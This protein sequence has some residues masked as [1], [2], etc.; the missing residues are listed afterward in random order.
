[1]MLCVV[2]SSM[3]AAVFAAGPNT[4]NTDW[5][6]G[7]AAYARDDFAAALSAF[8]A[9]RDAGQQGPAV[10]YNIAVC[11]FKLGKFDD[12]RATFEILARDFPAMRPL[13]NYN[14]GLVAVE[15]QRTADAHR[16]FLA[17][18]RES[19]D[20]ATLRVLASTMLRRTESP[21]DSK[22]LHKWRGAFAAR[23]GYDDNIVLR[24]ETGVPV[25]TATASPSL[26]AFG[27]L[28]IPVT[29]RD[30]LA[31]EASAYGVRYSA[32]DDFN[33]T[34]VRLGIGYAW[35]Q[36]TWN[37]RV[38]AHYGHGTFGGAAYDNSGSVEIVAARPLA[39]A[40]LL[41]IRYRY[42]A[43]NA[44]AAEF[45]GIDGRQQRVELGYRW[46]GPLARF[47][48]ALQYEDNDRDDAGLAASRKR[49]RLAY[50]QAFGMHWR[51]ELNGEYRA[52]RYAELQ[53]ARTENLVSIGAGLAR[54]VGNG[55]EVL[56]EIRYSDN[57]SSNPAFSY[58]RSHVSIGLLRDF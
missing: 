23:A 51:Y 37:G 16:Y 53:P 14:L 45:S 46:R 36:H 22:P 38:A 7:L 52:S 58:Q 54:D 48:A 1:M 24:D 3:P 4:A 35:Q 17:A 2:L 55:W 11:E 33:Q 43:I 32:N 20:D 6:D 15:Q 18:Y 57:A 30:G 27:S 34:S 39:T 47:D 13:A 21:G 44:A 5:E 28:L 31:L 10:H 50:R 8:R 12:A 56:T 9:A 49:I 40:S 19:V 41:Q 26:D 42:S 25:D 29:G